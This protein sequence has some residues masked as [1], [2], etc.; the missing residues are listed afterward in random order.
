[1]KKQHIYLQDILERIRLIEQFTAD[2]REIF[3]ESV[4][5]QEGVIRCFE[6][7]GEIV[8]RISP[9]LTA[10]HPQIPWRQ[11]AGFRDVLIHDYDETD[12]QVVWE[13]VEEDLIPLKQAVEAMLE[14]IAKTGDD[15]SS[16]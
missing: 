1:M 16:D 6:V 11:I 7:I 15:I 8:K 2:G 4:L 14:Q 13:I 10:A 5:I 12:T 9:E 3:L